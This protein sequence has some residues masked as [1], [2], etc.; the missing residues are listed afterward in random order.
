MEQE[1][2]PGRGWPRPRTTNRRDRSRERHGARLL[3]AS[4]GAGLVGFMLLLPGCLHRHAVTTFK[5][6]SLVEVRLQ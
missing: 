1:Q 4:Y 6:P 5:G 3:P 2:G